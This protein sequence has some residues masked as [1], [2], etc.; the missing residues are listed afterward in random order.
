MRVLVVQT[1][2]L[3]DL[4]LT[5]PLLR[6]IVRARPEARVTVVTTTIGRDVFRGLPYVAEVR[7]LD[8][9]PGLRGWRDALTLAGELKRD[10]F[11]WAVAAQRSHRSALLVR[12]SAAR[13]VGFAGAPGRWAYDLRVVRRGERHAVRR[14][15][16]L[17]RPLGGR[18]EIADP[19]PEMRPDAS[20]RDRVQEHL[21]ALGG[22]PY[23]CVAPGSVW[24]TKRWLPEGFG[25]VARALGREGARV[26]L[27][28]SAAE[29]ELCRDVA[30][31]AGSSVLDLAG[32][33]S[34]A[35]LAA[36]L[37]CARLLVGNDSGP[38]HVASA[39]GTPVVTLF[40]PTTPAMG[41][42]PHGALNRVVE[43]EGLECRPCHRHGPQRC[44][45][46]HF[47]CMREIPAIRVLATVRAALDARGADVQ[48]PGVERR[49]G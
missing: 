42:T 6:E 25:E 48:P 40:G 45:L 33:T 47:R 15:L 8:K 11:D 14:Y 3:G 34:V 38:A 26:V 49:P 17:S 19:R 22:E 20:A 36:L 35:E 32:R 16:E 10:G 13:R 43:H 46:G 12:K 31:A 29:R 44:P 18:P 28:G 21:Q 30:R 41:Y 1:A 5:T 37:E 24:G 2:F 27:V 4:V 9:R 39:V 7:A 23:V